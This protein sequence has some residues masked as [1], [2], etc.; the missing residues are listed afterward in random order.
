MMKLSTMATGLASEDVMN[1]LIKNWAHDE[2]TIRLWRASSNFVIAYSKDEEHYFLRFSFEQEKSIEH[3]QAELEY[4]S[5]LNVN[6][7]PCV[8]PVASLNGNYIEATQSPEGK[9]YAVVFKAAQGISLDENLTE[10]QFEDWG[11]ALGTLHRLSEAYEPVSTKRGD[12]QDVLN[13]MASILQRHHEKEAI[14]ELEHL[15]KELQAIPVLKSNYGLIH[16]DFQLDNLFYE[17]DTR[18][19]HVIDFDDAFYSWYVQ[20]IVTALDDI[21]ED[22]LTLDSPPVKAFLNGYKSV[23]PVSKEE[24]ACLPIFKR[25]MKLYKFSR[26]L[27]SLEG[28]ELENAPEWLPPIKMKFENVRDQLRSSFKNAI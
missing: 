7:Y 20:D 17:D 14:V 28:V 18:I 24:L 21:L 12:W 16:Y 2:E 15:I 19:F 26:I 27:W 8:S 3:I 10:L 1:S 11:K 6:R 13:G 25:F 22:E 23:K 4:M 5:Y 9:Y